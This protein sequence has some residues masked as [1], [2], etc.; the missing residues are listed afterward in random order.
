VSD[1]VFPCDVEFSDAGWSEPVLWLQ[2]G[3][4][5][6]FHLSLTDSSAT[7]EGRGRVLRA[8]L[9]SRSRRLSDI[10]S[11]EKNGRVV[12]LRF[13]DGAWWTLDTL[14]HAAAIIDALVARSVPLLPG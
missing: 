2:R 14:H 7:V 9:P 6:L 8:I 5:H 10:E 4:P 1:P 13:A 11:A 3:T 12:Y